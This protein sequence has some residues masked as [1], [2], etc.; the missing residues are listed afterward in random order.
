MKTGQA[1]AIIMAGKMATRQA[2]RV[3]GRCTWELDSV[4]HKCGGNR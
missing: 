4:G 2:R 1:G 3:S